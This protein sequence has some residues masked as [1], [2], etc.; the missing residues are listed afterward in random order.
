[1]SIER[2]T[3]NP[4]NEADWLAMRADDLTSTEAAALF[5]SSPYATEYELFMRK[6]KRVVAE[7][8]ENER[9]TWGK[10]LESAIAAG[11]AEDYGLI[12][13]P[14]K[15]YMRIPSLRMGASFDFKIVGLVDGAQDNEARRMFLRHGPGIMEIKNVDGLQF[16]RAWIDDGDEIEAPAHI[17]FQVQH[18]LEVAGLGWSM[19][20]PLVGGN[21]PKVSLR[22]RDTEVG[23]LIRQKVAEFWMR[24]DAGAAPEPDYT[25]DGDT[26]KQLYRDNDGSSVDM[27]DDPR[28]A[29]LCSSYKAAGA[30][31]KAAKERKD[32]CMAE[33]IT[34]IGHAKSIRAA[35]HNIS[36]GTNKESYRAFH[37]EE[38]KR[39]TV[40][41]STIPA[42]DLEYTVKPFRNVRITPNKAA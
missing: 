15:A 24:V 11:I 7:F 1:M 12:V 33:I 18:Q 40:S 2:V 23:A 4:A 14:F 35:G 20:A 5:G 6:T 10:R 31:E 25:R 39:Y 27:S 8:K 42:A 37:R 22:E 19:I 34:I 41:V 26:I 16:R 3:M 28:L 21:T 13:E 36:A 32:A 30:E 9:M 17:E 29:V 38:S